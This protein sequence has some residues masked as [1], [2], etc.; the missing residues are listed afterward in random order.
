MYHHQA[1]R[2]PDAAAFRKAMDTEIKDQMN[3]GNFTVMRRSK[4][5]ED[6]AILP[7]VWQMKRKRDIK[8]G[9]IIKHKARLNIDGSRMK[10]GIHYEETYAPVANWSS[11]RL[12]F[13]LITALKWHSIQLDYVQAFPQAPVEKPLYLKIPTGFRMSQGNP[14]DFVLR[15]DRNVYGQRQAGRIWNK[16]LVD[17]LTKDL[18]FKQSSYDECIFYRGSSIYLLYT[19]DSI[20]AGPN[21]DELETII[22][23]I[24]SS[25]LNITILGDVN[26]FLGVH[27]SKEQD[28]R[29]HVSQ[30]HLINQIIKTTFQT[31]A[32]PKP[33]PAKSS[34]ILYRSL[35]SHTPEFNYR[36][37]IGKLNYLERGSRSDISYATHQCARFCSDPKR[38]HVEAVRWLVR[39]LIGTRD[40][41]YY[42]D[43]DS[44]R[45]LEV[46][47]DADFSG[48]WD[49]SE[50]E[51]D[52]D[53]AR[54]RHGYIIS[55]MGAPIIWKSQL[56]TEIAL[57]STESEYTGLS[58]ALC[59]AIPIM[60]MLQEIRGQGTTINDSLPV[61]KCRVFE[62][63][64]GALEMA[65][66]H[67]FR[68][69][70]KHINVKLH[71][72]RDYV[73]R[74]MVVIE[75][76]RT[77]HQLADYLTKPLTAE[78]LCPLRK[79]VMGW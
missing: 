58:Y 42:I 78:V 28:G 8:T 76:I 29:I 33:T 60:H 27:V 36:T 65:I 14:K 70:T 22:K 17:I 35:A 12:L 72:F 5:P 51:H 41:G 43:P 47:V 6:A 79:R 57:S 48:N 9:K 63:N 20:L 75:P 3:N 45:G 19:D 25:G 7:T 18:R 71:H 30:P 77:K 49:P 69:R 44:T 59:E 68:P 4:I 10:K 26:D 74:G 55:Y 37:V 53:T 23:D 38:P 11:V 40:K 62:D 56:Q 39:Y 21:R 31:N 16:Y 15:V 73:T 2:Q 1:M 32:K 67:K 34:A 50:P 46:H 54:S 64:S 13:T 52:Q 61:V 66:T 24:K